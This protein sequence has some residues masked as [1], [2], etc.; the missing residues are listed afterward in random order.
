MKKKEIIKISLKAYENALN[1]IKTKKMNFN[2]TNKFLEKKDL[3]RGV[4]NFLE[5][6]KKISD[7]SPST[8]WVKNYYKT[9]S[10]GTTVEKDSFVIPCYWAKVPRHCETRKEIVDVLTI[11]RDILK[12]ELKTCK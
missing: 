9:D 5:L 8:R 12:K 3:E 11:R 2:T 4:C 6:T 10:N 1:E 7:A